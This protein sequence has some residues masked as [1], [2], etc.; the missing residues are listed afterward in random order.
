MKPGIQKPHCTANS[1][2]NACW[3]AACH[4]VGHALDRCDAVA[5]DLSGRHE[6]RHDGITIE[7]HGAGTALALGA[8]LLGSCQP[9]LVAQPVEQG[10]RGGVSATR[11][12]AVEHHLDLGVVVDR[13]PLAGAGRHIA[14]QARHPAR[15]LMVGGTGANGVERT[16][17]KGRDECRAVGGGRADIVER[18]HRCGWISAH[19]AIDVSSSARP[20]SAAAASWSTS[21]R[22]ATE[23]IAMRASRT[24]PSS[25][26]S[27]TIPR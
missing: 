19:A 7:L 22:A 20:M 13:P 23:P 9:G 2:T 8:P 11:R 16:T 17:D 4:R 5:V 18:C 24:T 10:R 15:P 27:T 12:R 3:I 6:A 1:S 25:A 26:R 14:D 21:T